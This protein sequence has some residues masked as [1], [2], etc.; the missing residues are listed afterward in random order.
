MHSCIVNDPYRNCPKWAD[1]IIENAYKQICENPDSIPAFRNSTLS[2][3]QFK[4]YY[5]QNVE[6]NPNTLLVGFFK[7]DKLNNDVMPVGAV[8]LSINTPWF[9]TE[10]YL[11]E[12]M[13]VSFEPGHGIAGAVADFMEEYA[14]KHDIHLIGAACANEAY[15]PIVTNAYKKRGFK[16]YPTF[17][18]EI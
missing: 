15:S 16:V 8:F 7:G 18:K 13:T 17:Y 5:E 6:F 2:L 9:S 4:E 14:K 3:E 12:V 10:K 11:E 1:F